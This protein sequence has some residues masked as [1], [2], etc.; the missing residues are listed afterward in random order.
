MNAFGVVRHAP[1]DLDT[2]SLLASEPDDEGAYV[3][4]MTLQ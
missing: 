3:L 4:T 1:R 2:V